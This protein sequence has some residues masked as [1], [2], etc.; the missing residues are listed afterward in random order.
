MKKFIKLSVIGSSLFCTLGFASPIKQAGYVSLDSDISYLVFN[1]RAKLKDGFMPS[2]GLNYNF[3][4]KNSVGLSLGWVR[5]HWQHS[6]SKDIN[7]GLY[8]LDYKRH[9]NVNSR[10]QPFITAGMGY[11]H[12]KSPSQPT[13]LFNLS[14]GAGMD[15]MLTKRI[16]AQ[17]MI[18]DLFTPKNHRHNGVFGVGISYRFLASG[19]VDHQPYTNN[20]APVAN[21][22]ACFSENHPRSA[23]I[24]FKNNSSVLSGK[25]KK[26]LSQL[27]RCLKKRNDKKLYVVGYASWPGTTR[28]NDW[29]SKKRALTIKRYLEKYHLYNIQVSAV[30]SHLSEHNNVPVDRRAVII[31]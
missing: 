20:M 27:A 1:N 23:T 21:K 17:A 12:I 5:S 15:Y 7:G 9:F 30:G 13:D 8:L 14:F 19:E 26:Q 25:S 6:H 22:N 24:Y 31:K 28:Y 10:Y 18:K 4:R 29:I 2:I 11:S 16:A 3:N